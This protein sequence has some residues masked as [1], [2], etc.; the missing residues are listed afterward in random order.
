MRSAIGL[1]GAKEFLAAS[2]VL[3]CAIGGSP[4]SAATLTVN[5]LD[6]S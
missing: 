3:V 4:A 2:L 5:T 6:F 1:C